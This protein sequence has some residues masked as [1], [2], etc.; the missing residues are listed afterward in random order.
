MVL[1]SDHLLGVLSSSVNLIHLPRNLTYDSRRRVFLL[2]LLGLIFQ[3]VPDLIRLQPCFSP[4]D[5]IRRFRARALV[6]VVLKSSLEVKILSFEL[7]L[8]SFFLI[9]VLGSCLRKIWTH[10]ITFVEIDH[11]IFF[12]HAQNLEQRLFAKSFLILRRFRTLSIMLLVGGL[13]VDIQR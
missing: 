2:I 7:E 10:F 6:V 11:L 12:V 13:Y 4:T 8:Q 1:P 9:C 5:V 3:I